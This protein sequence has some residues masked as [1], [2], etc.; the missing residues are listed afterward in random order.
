MR[1]QHWDC[2]V[3]TPLRQSVWL[4]QLERRAAL[5]LYSLRKS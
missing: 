3:T 5:R 2:R 1:N 4:S